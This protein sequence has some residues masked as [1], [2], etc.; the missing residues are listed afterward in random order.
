MQCSPMI[1]LSAFI[2]T[3]AE[4]SCVVTPGG[5]ITQLLGGDTLKI[6]ILCCNV[7]CFFQHAMT[8]PSY[9]LTHGM[10]PD[11]V[12]NSLGNCGMRQPNYGERNDMSTE[13]KKGIVLSLC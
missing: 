13:R 5:T 12:R 11:H 1:V 3:T 6:V 10:N 7:F 8:H 2:T 4:Y 9:R